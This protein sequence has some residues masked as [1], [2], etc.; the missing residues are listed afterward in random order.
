[1]NCADEQEVVF[2]V[3]FGPGKTITLRRGHRDGSVVATGEVCEDKQ[4]SS[5][6]KMGDEVTVT[7]EHVPRRMLML[8]AKTT[9]AIDGK[10][11]Y[12]KNYTDLFDASNDKLIAQYSPVEVENKEN[13]TGDLLITEDEM[14]GLR[15]LVV[16]SAIILQQRADARKRA[17]TSHSYRLQLIPRVLSVDAFFSMPLRWASFIIV[18]NHVLIWAQ[19]MY[20]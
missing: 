13:K 6:V 3:D 7:L 9:F 4:G 1:M 14:T 16:I 12:W 17:V 15:D 8:P 10:K 18:Y 5:E 2:Y 11:Y 19:L 20:S